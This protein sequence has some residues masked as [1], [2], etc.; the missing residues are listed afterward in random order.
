[1]ASLFPPFQYLLLILTKEDKEA[2]KV[3]CSCRIYE[4]ADVLFAGSVA[5]EGFV[6]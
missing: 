4:K 5:Y 2:M 6:P 1:M 3:F